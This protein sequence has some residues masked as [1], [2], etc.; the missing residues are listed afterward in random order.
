MSHKSE[1]LLK[2]KLR[3]QKYNSMET[4]MATVIHMETDI[5]SNCCHLVYGKTN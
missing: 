4:G 3:C 2:I 5:I 1:Y